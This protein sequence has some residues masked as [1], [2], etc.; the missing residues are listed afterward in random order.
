MRRVLGIVVYFLITFLPMQFGLAG[1]DLFQWTDANGVIHF[2]DNPYAVPES[3]R[4]SPQ[5]I[6]RKDFLINGQP[7][8]E[9]EVRTATVA[10]QDEPEMKEDSDL[11]SQP[12]PA[13]VN[14]PPQE[15]TVIVV[16]ARHRRKI[17]S[18]NVGQN[19]KPGFHPDF[20]S[21]Q[22]IHPSVF[23]RGSRQYI[24]P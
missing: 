12:G 22:H 7:S 3:V 24:H 23:D 10:K 20:N 11:D 1:V 5:L 21:R 8:K 14:Y 13:L 6:V 17:G 15:I 18:C 2:T 16:N 4:R 9:A 19:C